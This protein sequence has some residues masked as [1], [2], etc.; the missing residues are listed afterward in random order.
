MPLAKPCIDCGAPTNRTRCD[1]CST[2]KNRA[3]RAGSYYQTSSWRKLSRQVKQRDQG[4]C[5]LCSSTNRVQAHHIRHR[6]EGGLDELD[7]LVSL[8][9][10]CHRRI[11]ND[12][13]LDA[14]LK[15][16]SGNET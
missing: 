7:N 6:R 1:T 14:I 3:A 12:P 10:S 11:H 16:V 4:E 13:E 9:A 5:A 15:G 8:C 2:I